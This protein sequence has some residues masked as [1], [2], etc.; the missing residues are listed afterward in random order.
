[1]S[2][3][4]P[5]PRPPLRVGRAAVPSPPLLLGTSCR[6]PYGGPVCW[7]LSSSVR[8]F[9]GRGTTEHKRLGEK[10]I[11]RFIQLGMGRRLEFF[12]TKRQV[13][14]RVPM[15][16]NVRPNLAY[17]HHLK[18]WLVFWYNR[19]GYQIFRRFSF[20]KRRGTNFENARQ[21]ALMFYRQIREMGFLRQHQKP[22]TG[23]SGVRGVI[24]DPKERLW[25]AYWQE[26]GIRRFRAFSV[27]ELGFDVAYK[28]AVAVRRQK[29]AETHVFKMKVF[30]VRRGSAR[31][32]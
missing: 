31:Y 19:P 7:G 3:P 1:M 21:K 24:F 16:Q 15:Y 18:R 20:G 9:G 4:S 6:S 23:R 2:M 11:P 29:L 32:N 8:F 17:D 5:L 27:L 14:T 12:W 30:R 22:E 10:K 26:H 25:V 13:R 28:A